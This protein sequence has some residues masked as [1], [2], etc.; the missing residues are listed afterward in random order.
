MFLGETVS[1]QT[2]L[3][4]LEE[5]YF[6]SAFR[7]IVTFLFPRTIGVFVLHLWKTQIRGAQNKIPV[8]PKAMSTLAFKCSLEPTPAAS[9]LCYPWTPAS[10]VFLQPLKK[11]EQLRDSLQQGLG[12]YLCLCL[13]HYFS[14][15]HYSFLNLANPYSSSPFRQ[16][17]LSETC[18]P[19]SPDRHS[20]TLNAEIYSA[21]QSP[22]RSDT[23]PFC[24]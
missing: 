9:L 6:F 10:R 13:G 24:H 4:L 17:A 12:T 7:F 15:P 2:L 3:H 20:V 18:L 23:G 14:P 11:A 21:S 16:P 1:L 22:A 19:T 5:C 8:P